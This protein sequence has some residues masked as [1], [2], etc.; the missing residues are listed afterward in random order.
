MRSRKFIGL[1]LATS[2]FAACQSDTYYI[3]GEANGFEDGT[4]VYLA[5]AEGAH[6]VLDSLVVSDGRF[7][8]DAPASDQLLCLIPSGATTPALY[9]FACP[10]N[11]YVELSTEKGLSRV[12]GTK[13][14]NAWQ[15]LNDTVAKYDGH[16]RTLFTADSISPQ[17]TYAASEQLYTTL[18]RRINEAA[19]NNNDNALGRFISSHYLPK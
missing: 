14:N 8:Y 3:K 9:F 1:V 4:V 15:A 16:L 13:V 7:A 2:L 18:T 11:A 17:K 10:G 5:E 12:S 6:R 19:I